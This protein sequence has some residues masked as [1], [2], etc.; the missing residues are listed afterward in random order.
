LEHVLFLH[1]LGRTLPTDELH[2]F[3]G[4]YVYHQLVIVAPPR[5][6]LWSHRL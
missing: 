4:G 6:A 2:H 5:P 1:I 3:S